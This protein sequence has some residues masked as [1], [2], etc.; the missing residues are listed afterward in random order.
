MAET[1]SELTDVIRR[2]RA[3]LLKEDIRCEQIL[4]FG[5]QARGTAHE[6]SDIDLIII[7]PDWAGYNERQRLEILG[8]VAIRLPAAI[9]AQGFTPDEIANHQLSSFWEYVLAE[10]VPIAA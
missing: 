3:E 6:W 4:L 2:F 8:A 5:S 10:A 7:S 9:Q 1:P